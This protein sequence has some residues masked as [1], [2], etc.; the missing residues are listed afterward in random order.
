MLN[1][2]WGST[3]PKYILNKT[4]ISLVLLLCASLT[5]FSVIGCTQLSPQWTLEDNYKIGDSMW[6]IISAFLTADPFYI[7]TEIYIITD[8]FTS[9]K[10]TVDDMISTLL[11]RDDVVV[12]D[13]WYE[14]YQLY[15]NTTQSAFPTTDLALAQSIDSWAENSQT[16]GPYYAKEIRFSEDE[17]YVYASRIYMT[18]T[19]TNWDYD[20]TIDNYHELTDFFKSYTTDGLRMFRFDTV[21]SFFI[22]N[23]SVI[24]ETLITLFIGIPVITIIVFLVLGH[25]QATL[26]VFLM[27][28]LTDVQLLGLCHWLNIDFDFF[29]GLCILLALGLTVDF[30]I[31]ITHRALDI[32]PNPDIKDVWE[33]KV[34]HT[35][36]VLY[37]VGSSVFHGS[38]STLLCVMP[39]A[40]AQPLKATQK[41]FIKL[42]LILL[43]GMFQGLF[44]LPCI[45]TLFP[46]SQKKQDTV[47]KEDQTQ[48]IQLSEIGGASVQDLN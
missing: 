24:G 10:H 7:G 2:L 18:Q 47:P 41:L 4:G 48:D 31:H 6:R 42:A 29:L 45:L 32:V 35:S 25:A 20:W 11:S 26:Y 22:S 8:S 1:D 43:C 13:G 37:S 28:I 17:S 21:T 30:N 33:R 36:R 38:F 16:R 27:M 14:N 12:V 46:L 9:H 15:L 39:G 23:D 5:I 34:D 44:V 3:F 19:T 40:I